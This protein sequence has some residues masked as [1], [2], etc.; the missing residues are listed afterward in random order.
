MGLSFISQF[1]VVFS[2]KEQCGTDK[3]ITN[4]IGLVPSK[5]KV[6]K[7]ENVELAKELHQQ[8]TKLSSGLAC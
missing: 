3:S 5:E 6:N 2:P 1:Y 8:K 7:I 4:K